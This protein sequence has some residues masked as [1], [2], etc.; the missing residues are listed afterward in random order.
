M[1]VFFKYFLQNFYNS[2][3]C[4]INF[5]HSVLTKNRFCIFDPIFELLLWQN[6][7]VTQNLIILENLVYVKRESFCFLTFFKNLNKS[8]VI[9]TWPQEF[10][11][12]SIYWPLTL[13]FKIL[14]LTK[15]VD[16][17]IV[18]DCAVK[19]LKSTHP[20]AQCSCNICNIL[21]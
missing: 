11:D 13:T 14:A 20:T 2:L 21:L 15:F 12:C 17:S 5:P 3:E 19:K 6:Q 16:Q 8:L 10:S 9:I 7:K 18:H 1:I 4:A